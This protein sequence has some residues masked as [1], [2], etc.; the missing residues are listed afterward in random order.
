[1][2]ATALLLLYFVALSRLCFNK[3]T[4]V[5]KGSSV[6]SLRYPDLHCVIL[7]ITTK[8]HTQFKIL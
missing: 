7:Y 6:F 2:R 3:Y 1:M 5:Y 4:L 8:T